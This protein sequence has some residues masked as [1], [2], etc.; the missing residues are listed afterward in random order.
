MRIGNI[1]NK[2]II[3]CLGSIQLAV[4]L[5]SVII[6]V[7]I[8]ATFY[9]AQVGA[10]VVQQQIY[11]SPW[12]GSLMFLLAINLGVSAL[13]RYPWRGARKVGFALTHLGII[14]II[15]GAAAVIHLGTEGLIL[16]RT[17]SNFNNQIRAEGE[18]LEVI[19]FDGKLKQTDL[20]IK[21]DGSI[22]KKKFAGLSL[23]E[24]QKN[25]I[26]TVEFIGQ[27]ETKNPAV[28][29]NL[30]SE[31]MGQSIERW[32]AIAPTPYSETALGPT[33]LIISP[34]NSTKEWQELVSSLS[35]EKKPTLG[36]L[37][38]TLAN[39]NNYTLNLTKD[40]NKIYNIEDKS[41]IRIINFWHD[42]RLDRNNKP[43]NASGEL[44]NP[45]FQLELTTNTSKEKWFVFANKNF[46]PVRSLIS[47]EPIAGV[48]ID[49]QLENNLGNN[50]FRVITTPTDN[51]YYIAKSS[52]GLKSGALELNKPINPGWLDF[53][54][55]LKEFIP[56][57]Q[58]NREIVP[59]QNEIAEGIPA[60]LVATES[61]QK[62]WL[63]WGEPTTITEN[64][65]EMYAAFGPKLRQLPFAIALEDFIVERNEGSESVAMWTSKIRLEN[66]V[67]RSVTNR[68]VWMNHPTWYQ[69][70]KIAQAS[71]NPGDLRQS[72]LQVKREPAWVTALTWTGSA[73]V[74]LG[75]A[76]MFYGPVISKHKTK[77]NSDLEQKELEVSAIK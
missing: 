59:I 37:K 11:R 47:G 72:T 30:S 50:Y 63:P 19:D 8:E 15:A 46:P 39:G 52:Q 56:N 68:R 57:A 36:V 5:L 34:V 64:K 69:G 49:Y 18:L 43:S 55:T 4:P 28:K 29:L 2:G 14:I 23:L 73:L 6:L 21:H 65:S 74:I 32:L 58:I 77:I 10:S 22:S 41:Q 61:G 40:L 3:H 75:I 12:F 45:A 35:K 9:E 70:W 54:I 51:L 48:T 31:S 71:W 20:F 42:F 44:K 13:S 76:W 25:T 1:N 26:K 7:L 38:I 66:P 53:K 33:K 24:Y 16:L 27:G 60:L 62:A 17:D 67:D